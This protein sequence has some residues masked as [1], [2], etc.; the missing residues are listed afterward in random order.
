MPQESD[1]SSSKSRFDECFAFTLK[2][3]GASGRVEH[4][5]R[6]PGGTTKFGID[7]GS[8]PGVDIEN[9]TLEQAKAIYRDEK[10][11][12]FQCDELRPP[13]DLLVFDS[14]VNPGPGFVVG[15]LQAAVGADIDGAMGP[16]TIEKTNQAGPAEV[17][18]FIQKRLDYYA[19]RPEELKQAYLTGWNNRTNDLRTEA[20]GAFTD[21]M[22]A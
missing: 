10:W 14:S 16:Q 7:Q 11:D 9:L 1:S 2:W 22:P 18:S 6:D 5:R 15:A 20:L 17:Q 21:T 19:S 12:K 8:H 3:E 4:D 13:W